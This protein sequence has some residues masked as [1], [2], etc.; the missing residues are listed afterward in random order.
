MCYNLNNTNSAP[1]VPP[2]KI[3]PG[4]SLPLPLKRLKSYPMPT[5]HFLG[6]LLKHLTVPLTQFPYFMAVIWILSATVPLVYNKMFLP[7]EIYV[8]AVNIVIAYIFSLPLS[9]MSKWL[10]CTYMAILLICFLIFCCIELVAVSQFGFVGFSQ[11]LDVILSTNINEISEFFQ[12]N[13]TF[14]IIRPVLVTVILCVASWIALKYATMHFSSAKYPKS[15]YAYKFCAL[16]CIAICFAMTAHNPSALRLE[17]IPGK[18]ARIRLMSHPSI[19]EFLTDMEIVPANGVTEGKPHNLVIIIGES[20]ARKQSS[21]YGYEKMTNPRLGTLAKAGSLH[22]F[23]SI[24]APATNTISSFK[25]FMSTYRGGNGTPYYDAPNIPHVAS[26]IG[27]KTFW[28]SSQNFGGIDHN[29]INLYS[30]ICDTMI[31]KQL[32]NN[33]M[34]GKTDVKYDDCLLPPIREIAADTTVS[35]CIFVHMMGSHSIF[36][37]RYPPQHTFFTPEMYPQ[38]QNARNKEVMA[39][40][41]NS[42]RFNDSVVSDIMDTFADQESLVIY[43]SDHGLDLYDTRHDYAAH[44]RPDDPASFEAGTRIPFMIYTS[45]SYM[46]THPHTLERIKASLH[47]KWNT[48]DLIYTILDLSGYQPTSFDPQSQGSLLE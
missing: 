20:F 21:L 22:L 41:D 2:T 12:G 35:K 5:K 18:I 4:F 27:Y 44:G 29:T 33:N 17:T 24:S 47:R 23:N 25:Q 7:Y 14:S 16:L 6:N 10:R 30:Q 3:I 15:S 43:F 37:L 1:N 32:F 31:Y 28:I 45:P 19:E 38:F 42:V 26:Q 9:F 46:A 11:L 40:Y 48:T 39:D 8:I 34:I 36:K 13:T